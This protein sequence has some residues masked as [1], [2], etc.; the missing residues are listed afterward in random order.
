MLGLPV[1]AVMALYTS[2]GVFGLWWGFVIG[3]SVL[4]CLYFYALTRVDFQAE[5]SE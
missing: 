4:C 2:V 5:V 3:L 1:G